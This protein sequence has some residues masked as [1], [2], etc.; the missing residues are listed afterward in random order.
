M[1]EKEYTEAYPEDYGANVRC[2]ECKEEVRIMKFSG[3]T[4]AGI[5]GCPWTIWLKE[6]TGRLQRCTPLDR[7]K[8]WV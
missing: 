1:F 7:K 4:E 2:A 8:N 3:W 6:E 5:C